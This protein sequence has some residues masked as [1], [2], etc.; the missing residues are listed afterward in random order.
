M[1]GWGSVR[2]RDG[3]RCSGGRGRRERGIV[4]VRRGWGGGLP[5]GRR[6]HVAAGAA[7]WADIGDA[8][9]SLEGAVLRDVVHA[10]APRASACARA[11]ASAARRACVGSAR[12]SARE[13]V[14]AHPQS[15]SPH[16]MPTKAPTSSGSHPKPSAPSSPLTSPAPRPQP[17]ARSARPQRRV[18]ASATRC[19]PAECPTNTSGGGRKVQ[20]VASSSTA[21]V[22]AGASG[23]RGGRSLS[24][25]VRSGRQNCCR[26]QRIDLEMSSTI[27]SQAPCGWRV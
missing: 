14:R 6:E 7:H 5:A 20:S 4:G 11:R 17:A 27:C 19:A 21:D 23:N 15:Q 18:K 2:Q 1:W 24:P 25:P 8:A 22:A 10:T 3:W 13:R 16:L 9:A 12:T 26:V